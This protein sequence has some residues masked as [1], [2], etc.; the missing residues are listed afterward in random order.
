MTRIEILEMTAQAFL[1]EENKMMRTSELQTLVA[2]AHSQDER[3]FYVL[4][5]NF[6]LG[7][8]QKEVMAKEHY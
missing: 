3:D 1:G 4:I 7:K 6:L 8:R 2:N 5:Y